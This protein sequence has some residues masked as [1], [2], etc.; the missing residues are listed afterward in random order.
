MYV[1]DMDGKGVGSDYYLSIPRFH[2]EFS[3]SSSAVAA[4]LVELSECE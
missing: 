2:R 4:A 1:R 3:K